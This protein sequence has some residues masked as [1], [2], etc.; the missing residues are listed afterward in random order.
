MMKRIAFLIIGILFVNI[1][2]AQKLTPLQK[3][4]T[5]FFKNKDYYNSIKLYDKALKKSSDTLAKYAYFQIAEC[6][7]FGN[8]FTEAKSWYE[9]AITA[10]S[11]NPLANLRIGEMLILSGEYSAAKTYLEKYISEVPTDNLAKIRLEACNLGLKGQTIKPILQVHDVTELNSTASDYGIAYFTKN[12]YIFA[13]TRPVAAIGNKI[14]S[15]TS[16]CFSDM[17]ETTYDT[18][19]FST[20][21]RLSAPINTSFNEGTFSF[22]PKGNYGY[23]S[24]CNG[25]TGKLHQ[26]NI[27]YSHYNAA[28]NTWETSRLFPFNSQS[29]RIQQPSVSSDGKTMYFSSDMPGGFGGADLYMIKKVSDSIWGKPENLGALINTIGNEGFPYISGDTLLVFASDGQAGFGGLDIFTSSYKNGKFNKPVNMMT[30]INSSADDF[31][32]IFKDSKN[33]GFFCSNRIGGVGDDD[34]YYFDLVPVIL[35]AVGNVKDKTSGVGLDNAIVYFKATDGT[36]DSAI[37]DNT[38]KYTFTR[39]K[40]N[41]KYTIKATR[42]GY[43]N[44]SKGFKSET[45]VYSRTYDKTGGYDLDFALIKITKEEVKIDNIYYDYDKA[46]L[47][48]ESKIELDKLI[49]ILKETPEVN[50]QISSH[51][52]ER[53][54]EKYNTELSQ[55]RAQSVVDYLISGGISSN[56][57]IAK[58]YG[59][60]KPIIKGAKTEE[61]HQMNRRTTFKIL[62]TN[63]NVSLDSYIESTPNNPVGVSKFYIISAS[64]NSQNEADDA[65]E[66]LKK[67]GYAKALVVG[68]SETNKWWVSYSE[69]KSKAEA[70]TAL[71]TIKKTNASAW[72]YE[73]K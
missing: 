57:L 26:C 71:E 7:R 53:G 15:Y 56:R 54:A 22:D 52:D 69:Y 43:L 63:N 68:L 29:F 1:L 60:S 9:K 28:S 20:P 66:S 14:D 33:E 6:Y 18:G 55:K 58:G 46:D 4:D 12:K 70:A 23:Y 50:V 38:G 65:V 44:D 36:I 10:G 72:I 45:E 32:L 41:M 11:L 24:Q 61:E 13:S 21:T 47:R 8:N 16:Q 5:A 3:A 48:P 37:T 27:M 39:V 51:S 25:E 2:T 62:S 31:N 17:Y 35:T 73:K 67:A 19:K 59:F 34:I 49:N 30:P 64:Y 42:E 40:Q